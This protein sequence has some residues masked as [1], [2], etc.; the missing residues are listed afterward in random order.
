M[1]YEVFIRNE[2][3]R[4]SSTAYHYRVRDVVGDLLPKSAPVA[5]A[6]S[7][8]SRRIHKHPHTE[9]AKSLRLF[10][11]GEL[12][13]MEAREQCASREQPF[14][15]D[16]QRRLRRDRGEPHNGKSAAS[17]NTRY[18]S[19]QMIARRNLKGNAL[20]AVTLAVNVR[21]SR[22]EQNELL[23]VRRACDGQKCWR[24]VEGK[25]LL[26]VQRDCVGQNSWRKR[27]EL[28]VVRRGCVGQNCW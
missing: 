18:C 20:L 13:G 23:A 9:L 3:P 24:E 26:S 21:S 14:D 15:S 11:G 28:L 6:R 2:P 19:S 10:L 8:S 4:I 12:P 5:R 27:E 16:H 22:L 25:G 7:R 17:R 1:C